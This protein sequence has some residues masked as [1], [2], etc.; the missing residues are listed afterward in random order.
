M[1]GCDGIGEVW[2]R[3]VSSGGVIASAVWEVHLPEI[4]D[5]TPW[6]DLGTYFPL[7]S[8]SLLFSLSFLFK[9][10]A[11]RRQRTAP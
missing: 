6:L 8:F 7:L 10:R 1:E 11:S 3:T 9:K 2:I 5:T 4:F